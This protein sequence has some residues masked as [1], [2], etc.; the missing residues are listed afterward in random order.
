MALSKEANRFALLALVASNLATIAL[1]IALDWNLFTIWGFWVQS[2][3]IGASSYKKLLP[4]KDLARFFALHYGAFH[5]LYGIFLFA[6]SLVASQTV[7]WAGVSII[8]I[9]FALNHAFSYQTYQNQPRTEKRAPTESDMWKPYGRIIPMHVT[10][11][12]ALPFLGT[13]EG[14]KIILVAFLLLK[15]IMDI[16]GHIYEHTQPSA[17]A[18]NMQS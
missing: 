11:N 10:I 9:A 16:V 4:R 8:G 2:V 6:F 5:I 15:A 12:L 14:Q 17:A 13:I 18:Q 3:I 1:A 7:D